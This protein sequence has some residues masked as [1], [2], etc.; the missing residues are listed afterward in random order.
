MPDL[1]S[2]L[3]STNP[4]TDF[5]AGLILMYDN[6]LQCGKITDTNTTEILARLRAQS[7]IALRGL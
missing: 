4:M 6:M 3:N 1:F 5:H 2:Q 7:D